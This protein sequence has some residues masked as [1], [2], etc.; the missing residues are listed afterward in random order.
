MGGSGKVATFSEPSTLRIFKFKDGS[1]SQESVDANTFIQVGGWTHPLI[2]GKSPVLE[3]GNGA[4]MFPDVYE[5]GNAGGEPSAVGIV[6]AD[7][8]PFNIE[9]E[10]QSAL[11]KILGELTDGSLKKEEPLSKDQRLG[12]VART[13]VKGAE[14]MSMGME[15]GAEKATTLIE[16]AGEN[17]GLKTEATAEDTKISPAYKATAKGAM[18]ATLATVKVSGFVAK[19]VG[20]LSKGVSNYLAKKLEDP[21]VRATGGGSDSGTKMKSSGSM[22]QIANVAYGGL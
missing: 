4:F 11:E 18:Y 10:A 1:P 12:T 21:A 20:N 3:A 5:E 2:P 6:I 15:K 9:G 19:R 16:Y 7:D 8:T 22:R 14:L 13:L 17:K